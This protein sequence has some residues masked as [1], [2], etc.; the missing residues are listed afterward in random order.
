MK[1]FNLIHILALV[2]EDAL[3]FPDADS[4][5]ES[6]DKMK[7]RKITKVYSMLWAYRVHNST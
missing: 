6:K 1:I 4:L 2:L 7:S 3:Y 5:A